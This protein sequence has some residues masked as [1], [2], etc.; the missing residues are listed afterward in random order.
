MKRIV[1][2]MLCLAVLMGTGNALAASWPLLYEVR[3]DQDHV[4]YLL[5]TIHVGKESTYPLSRPVEDA[6]AAADVLAVEVDLYRFMKNPLN[7]IKYTLALMYGLGD[8]I[9]NHISPETYAL[10]VETLGMP[11][12]ALRLYRPMA[13]LSLAENQVYERAGFS[14]DYGVDLHLSQRAQADGKRLDELESMDFQLSLMARLPDDVID[15][16]LYRTMK[17][18]ELESLAIQRLYHAWKLG[19]EWW[20]ARLLSQDGGA[21]SQE[22]ADSYTAYEAALLTDRNAGFEEKAVAY[23]EKG[24]TALIAIGAAHIVGDDGLAARLRR[25][26]YEVKE[27]GRPFGVAAPGGDEENER[28]R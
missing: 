13:W 7:S 24:E 6:Y 16:M 21:E 26:G 14:S 25:A 20:L 11:E 19:S 9:Q 22:M 2:L 4:I 3:D 8:S 1:A 28:G 12:V 23:L 27:I 18:P 17:Y 10:G 5:G 15:A